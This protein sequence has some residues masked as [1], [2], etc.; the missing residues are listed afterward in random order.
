MKTVT[1]QLYLSKINAR[2]LLLLLFACTY[3]YSQPKIYKTFAFPFSEIL[4]IK[5]YFKKSCVRI[6]DFYLTRTFFSQDLFSS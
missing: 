2:F 4:I 1:I 3:N 5:A 6:T